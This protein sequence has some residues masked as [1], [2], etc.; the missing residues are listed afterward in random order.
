MISVFTYGFKLADEN[1]KKAKCPVFSLCSYETLI[2]KAVDAN[3][4]SKSEV[5]TLKAWR[6]APDQWGK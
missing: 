6:E 5:K 1:F 2:E 3:Y 4:V